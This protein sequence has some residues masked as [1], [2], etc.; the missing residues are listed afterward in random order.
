MQAPPPG[1]GTP[2]PQPLQQISPVRLV[3]DGDA[4]RGAS[5]PVAHSRL[6]VSVGPPFSACCWRGRRYPWPPSHRH[7]RTIWLPGGFRRPPAILPTVHLQHLPGRREGWERLFKCSR[8]RRG[9]HIYSRRNLL[10]CCH[11]RLPTSRKRQ[12]Q[13]EQKKQRFFH[14]VTPLTTMVGFLYPQHLQ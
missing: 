10:A 8:D 5:A 6:I 2:P 3:I 9:R 12:G 1:L 11:R 14:F 13:T 4:G 7:R